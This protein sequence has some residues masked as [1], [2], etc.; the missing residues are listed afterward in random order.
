[1]LVNQGGAVGDR[2]FEVGDRF[3]RFVLD[4]DGGDSGFGCGHSGGGHSGHHFALEPDQI[5]GEQRA[6]GH[7][8]PERNVGHVVRGDDGEYTGSRSGRRHVKARDSRVAVLGV[9]KLRSQHPWKLEIG[10]VSARPGDLVGAIGPYK[11]RWL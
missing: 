3:Q 4:L 10:G 7:P 2:G 5:S 8:G 9:Q 6:V 11:T 1:M